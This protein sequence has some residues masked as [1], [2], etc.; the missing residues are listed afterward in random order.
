[1]ASRC[2]KVSWWTCP[3]KSLYQFDLLIVEIKSFSYQ[4][5]PRQVYRHNHICTLVCF[6]QHTFLENY[7]T[8]V[9]SL[10]KHKNDYLA[11]FCNRSC[12]KD[13]RR[14]KAN[15]TTTHRMGLLGKLTSRR[16]TRSGVHLLSPIH[17]EARGASRCSRTHG[18][19]CSAT[20][21][22]TEKGPLSPGSP[23]NIK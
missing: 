2:F 17:R 3:F 15:D 8:S 12:G 14:V 19:S 21:L 13:V 23:E 9:K 20:A 22:L 6:Y 5:T 18:S 7:M 16:S 10:G 11:F 1:M 4:P